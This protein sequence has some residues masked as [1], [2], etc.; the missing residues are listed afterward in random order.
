VTVSWHDAVAF[1]GFLSRAQANLEVRLPT[2]AEWEFAARAGLSGELGFDP[3]AEQL[4]DHAWVA[5]N[6]DGS[7]HMVGTK[8]PNAWGIHDMLG[9]AS[10]WCQD[11]MRSLSGVEP[12]AMWSNRRA[13]RGGSI[14]SRKDQCRAS[15]RQS[16]FADRYTSFTG[17]R[18]VAQIR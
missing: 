14:V 12:A 18:V 4:I 8:L 11:R 6:A 13:L 7:M 1:C 15:L 16:W 10:E 2:E 3:R 17:F 9:N 5:G